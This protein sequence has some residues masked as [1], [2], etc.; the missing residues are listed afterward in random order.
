MS[1]DAQAEAIK[2]LIATATKAPCL[3]HDEAQKLGSSVP[4]Q[5]TVIYLSRRFGG[6]M[7]GDTRENPL[8][9]LQTRVV[10]T[11]TT[12]GRLVEDRIADLFEHATH[13]VAGSLVHFEFEASDSEFDFDSTAGRYQRLT[14]WT[15]AV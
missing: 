11:S 5:Y 8:R 1:T 12:N 2:S 14:D 15:F 10:A 3:D 9:R 4:P 7:R 13:D 6:N